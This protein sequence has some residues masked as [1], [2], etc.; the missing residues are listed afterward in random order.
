V[1]KTMI[2][3]F[4]A[5]ALSLMT[6]ASDW[7]ETPLEKLNYTA[8]HLGSSPGELGYEA[9]GRN[10]DYRRH[11]L[12]AIEGKRAA[13][14]ALCEFTIA[15]IPPT[16]AQ[17]HGEVLANL[18]RHF[19]DNLFSAALRD[20]RS[21]VRRRVLSALDLQLGPDLPRTYRKTAELR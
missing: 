1:K 2:A 20:C 17:H 5:A 8:Q 6:V 11:L 3:H 13:V 15:E 18:L 21:S 7:R 16:A 9:K 4:L 14:I 10:F 12:Q 19:G